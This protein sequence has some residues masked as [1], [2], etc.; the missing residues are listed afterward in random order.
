MNN[1]SIAC[2]D[3]GSYSTGLLVVRRAQGLTK[4][5]HEQI[6]VTHLGEGLSETG[7]INDD[8]AARTLNSARDLIR[9]ADGFKPRMSIVGT[10]AL[11]QAENASTITDPIRDEF[12]KDVEIITAAE[13]GLLSAEGACSGI[14]GLKNPVVVD[15]GG[16]S[17]EIVWEDH[18]EKRIVSIDIGC[19]SVA[20]E[21]R[22]NAIDA[23]VSSSWISSR[24]DAALDGVDGPWNRH[25]ENFQIV[26]C[27]GTAAVLGGLESGR[28]LPD[29]LDHIHGMHMDTEKLAQWY[30]RLADTDDDGRVRLGVEADRAPV[31]GAGAGIISGIV[32]R[33]PAEAAVRISAR[34]LRWGVVTQ[35]M[36]HRQVFSIC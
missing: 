25:D 27:G 35:M 3:I 11:R 21:V 24:A 5:V 6:I 32:H 12:N 19:A 23:E 29:G 20:E 8:A 30:R 7:K 31:M 10:A 4:R 9:A 17:T 14:D 28:R 26:L 22:K 33:F 2:L 18:G 16:R 36:T 1:T 34:G 15:T 13:E